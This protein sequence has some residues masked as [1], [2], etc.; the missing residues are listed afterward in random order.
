MWAADFDPALVAALWYE[1][2]LTIASRY[3]GQVRCASDVPDGDDN[4]PD[5]RAALV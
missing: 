4:A 1:G 2:Y 3:T 5:L